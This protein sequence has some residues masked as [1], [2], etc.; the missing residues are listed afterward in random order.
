MDEAAKQARR[1]YGRKY[2][3]ANRE[4]IN[5]KKREYYQENRE[6]EDAR[7]KKW[8]AENPDKVKAI[9]QRYWEKKALEMA[10]RCAYCSEPFHPK[11]ST[12][13]FCSAK[14]RVYHNRNKA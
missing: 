3:E 4:R 1:A 10:P 9:E 13:K 2:R 8:K 14:C 11:R 7:V 6:K 12:A 5:K